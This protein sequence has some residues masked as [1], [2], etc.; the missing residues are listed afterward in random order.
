MLNILHIMNMKH[1]RVII[2]HSEQTTEVL[3]YVYS[4]FIVHYLS[5]I[6]SLST[7]LCNQNKNRYQMRY[8]GFK[9]KKIMT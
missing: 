3:F 6:I 8:K 1:F 2:K 9:K 7:K 4:E 5:F